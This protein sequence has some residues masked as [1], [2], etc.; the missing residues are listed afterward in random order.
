MR[1]HTAMLVGIT[2]LVAGIIAAISVAVTVIVSRAER[3]E[4]GA[5]LERSQRLFIDLL[6]YR[7]S[8]YRSDCQVV[9]NEPR[10]RAV[11]ATEDVSRETVVGVINELRTSLGSDLFLFTDAEG[12]LVA[13]AL[14]LDAIGFDLSEMEVIATARTRG[15]GS[16]VWVAESLPYQVQGCRVAFGSQVAGIIVI[17][18]RIGD[19]VAESVERLTGS[20]VVVAIDGRPVAGGDEGAT[21]APETIAGVTAG[22]EREIDIDGARY[23]AIGDVLPGYT[24]E[25]ALT[26]TAFRSIDEALAPAR[27][28]I[29]G[30]FVIAAISLLAGLLIAAALARR[31]SRPVAELVRFAARVGKGDLEARARP[32]GALEIKSLATAMNEMVTEIDASRRQLAEKERLERELEIAMRIQTSILPRSFEVHGLD[33]A[34]QMIPATEVGGD[35]Y[36]ILPGEDACWVGVGDVAG[37]GLTAGLEMLMVQSM[38]AAL[39]KENPAAAPSQHLG[40]VNRVLFENIRNRLDQDEHITLTLL[41]F[42]V[43]GRVT[44]AGAH[45]EIVVCRAAGGECERISTPGT[46]LGA[47]RDIDSFTE[48]STLELAPDDLVVLYSD[49]VTEA[50]NEARVQFG[51]E[52]LCEVVGEARAEPV[53]AIRDRIV[54]AVEAWQSAQEDDVSVVVIRRRAEDA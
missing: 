27:R 49:G 30:I 14:D 36:D 17:G 29:V 48:D 20:S 18:N 15:E 5:D 33:I 10:L 51:I 42:A 52:R 38:I 32:S 26:Y 39:V 28:L 3:S 23:L 1:L 35:Y 12:I 47:I 31:L 21:P 37:H 13:D 50:Q 45:E 40:V 34:A 46:W 19:E 16:G 9:A 7:Q 25:R 4:L 6:D 24:G 22:G 8:M 43:D 53:E 11:M 44:F 54:G 2:C 41:R